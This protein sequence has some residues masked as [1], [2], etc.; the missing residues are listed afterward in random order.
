MC[1]VSLKNAVD[2]I[3][4]FSLRAFETLAIGNHVM[5]QAPTR[6]HTDLARN[7]ALEGESNYIN[8]V[9]FL[10]PQDCQIY[11]VCLSVSQSCLIITSMRA[12]LVCSIPFPRGFAPNR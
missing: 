7:D 3:H 11:K 10:E 6:R 2:H 8:D 4:V 5:P 12:I 9:F 1:R